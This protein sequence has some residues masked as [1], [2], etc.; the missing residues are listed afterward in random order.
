M[1]KLR[2]A[3]QQGFTLI[4]LL[5]VMGIIVTLVGIS[6][7]NFARPQ[8]VAS[9][10][11]TVSQV[12]ADIKSQQL[13][14]MNGDQ[15]STVTQQAQGIVFNSGAYILFAGA[16]YSVNDTNNYVVDAGNGVT[17]TTTLPSNTVQFDKGT[18]AVVGYVNGSN[19]ITLTTSSG[20]AIITL[21]KF[22][23]VVVN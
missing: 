7:I 21:N 12:V 9:L 20:S 4:E 19:T 6:S 3:G 8:S 15:G 13:L 14:A 16:T 11:T 10:T 5:V 1:V 18:G 17:I 23:A 2:V 22:G